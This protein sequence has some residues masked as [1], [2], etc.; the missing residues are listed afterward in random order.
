MVMSPMHVTVVEVCQYGYVTKL[1][2]RGR[3]IE[4]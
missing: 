4:V 2:W 3:I 1:C